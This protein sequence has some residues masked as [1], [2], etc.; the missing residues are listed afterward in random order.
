MDCLNG[1]VPADEQSFLPGSHKTA[2]VHSRFVRAAGG[3]TTFESVPGV[4]PDGEKWDDMPGWKEAAC[5][6]GTLVLIHGESHLNQTEAL[7]TV[8]RE[9]DAPITTESVGQ[10]AADLYLP[11]DRGRQGACL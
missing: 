6:P 10:V 9:R 2:R 1:H 7:L 4:E 3:G 11:H 5:T 8:G